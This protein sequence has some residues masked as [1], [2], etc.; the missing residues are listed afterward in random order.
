MTVPLENL[1]ADVRKSDPDRWLAARFA[2]APRRSELAALYTF[3]HELARAPET[4]TNPL[5][6]EIRLAWWREGAEALF[7]DGAARHDALE[8]LRGPMREGRLSR[9]RLEAMIE[10]RHAEL[11]PIPF[12]DEA[13]LVSHI[14]ATA[15][16]LMAAAARLLGASDEMEPVRPAGRAWGW[17]GLLRAQ[18]WWSAKGR[19]WTPA[20]WG[21]PEPEEIAAHVRHRVADSLAESRTAL[22]A[23]PVAAFP[24]VA[25]ATLSR[26]YAGGR[27]LTELGKQARLVKAS[28]TGKL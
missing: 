3:N 22:A 16:A 10:A 20:A 11:N 19:R 12:A 23:L 8:V 28:L 6:G 9:E 25:Y 15:G 5:M 26:A 2:S 13:D 27:E 18:A 21:E 1:D 4:A 17:A 14:D 7:E 24:A